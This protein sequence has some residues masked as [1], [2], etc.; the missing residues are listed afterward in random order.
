M[1]YSVKYLFYLWA[2]V[3]VIYSCNNLPERPDYINQLP[4]VNSYQ[5]VESGDWN[6]DVLIDTLKAELWYNPEDEDNAVFST[7]TDFVKVGDRYWICDPMVGAIFEFDST[8]NYIRNITSKGRGPNETI[9]PSAMFASTTGKNSARNYVVDPG[10]KSILIFNGQGN[11]VQRISHSTI[12][13]NYF[14]SWIIALSENRL[15]WPTY[16][17]KEDVLVEA[18]TNA[19]VKRSFIKRLVPLG[20][21]PATHNGVVY[22]KQVANNKEVFAYRGLPVIFSHFKEKKY[23]INLLPGSK[24]EDINTP[25]EVPPAQ[26]QV[27]VKNIIKS[28]YSYKDKVFIHFRNKFIT[29][30]PNGA[31]I[32]GYVVIDDLGRA[33]IPQKMV[34]A[35]DNLFFI[36]R[37]NLEIYKLP[38]DSIGDF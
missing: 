5:Y 32:Q 20:K 34:L 21:Q 16:H 15:I 29:A 13:R 23:M 31:R 6:S 27:S 9:R 3:L 36:D 12:N 7:P 26:T 2:I 4:E 24:L 25:L 8:G 1:I 28:I 14:G 10:Q 35:E 18:D 38:L 33:I 17:L 30:K 22:G 19:V 37:F 11:E